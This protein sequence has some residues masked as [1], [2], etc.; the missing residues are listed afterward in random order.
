MTK[1]L[2]FG[3]AGRAGGA[4]VQDALERGWEVTGVVRSLAQKQFIERPGLTAV[5]GDVR[6]IEKLTGLVTGHQA[7]VSAVTPFSAPPDSFESFDQNFYRDLTQGLV[8]AMRVNGIRRLVTIGLAA[9]LRHPDGG[10]V[11]DSSELFPARLKPFATAHL[12]AVQY[13]EQQVADLGWAVV[14]PPPLLH[15][16]NRLGRVEVAAPQLVEGV[17]L[18]Y[19]EL[20]RAVN[21]EL[22]MLRQSG[23]QVAVFHRLSLEK[24]GL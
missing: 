6:S 5:L 14:T 1:I 8:E 15:A 7:V 19:L 22:T 23:A 9:T 3:A 24:T 10:L 11:M 16:E 12:R 20:A 18:S 2:V 4:I 13:L 17:D 21:D